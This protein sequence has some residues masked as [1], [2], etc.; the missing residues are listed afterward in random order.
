MDCSIVQQSPTLHLITQALN[1]LNRITAYMS[2]A[3][4]F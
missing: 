4:H 2:K 3:Y 1:R